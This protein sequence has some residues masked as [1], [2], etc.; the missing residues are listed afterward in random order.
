MI[1]ENQRKEENNVEEFISEDEKR[2]KRRTRR[3]HSQIVAYSVLLVMLLCIAVAGTIGIKKVV[4][5]ISKANATQKLASETENESQTATNDI[6]ILTPEED[7]PL[8]SSLSDED[9]ETIEKTIE[10]MSL[11]DKVASLFITTPEQITGVQSAIK[12]GT[13][14]QEALSNYAIGGLVYSSN[15]IKDEEQI[16]EMLSQTSNLSRYPIFLAVSEEG[17]EASIV[18]SALSLGG[19]SAFQDIADADDAYENASQMASYLDKYGFNLNLA[20]CVDMT[21]DSGSF[22]TDTEDVKEKAASYVKG[23][24]EAGVSS[25]TLSFPVSSKYISDCTYTADEIAENIYPIYEELIDADVDLIMVSNVTCKSLT[26]D[27]S[28]SCSMSSDIYSILRDELSFDKVIISDKLNDEKITSKYS[29]GDA[30]INA[31]NA[32]CD[33]LYLPEN[34]EEAYEAIL[35]AL[36]NGTIEESRIDESLYR[37]YNVKYARK[38]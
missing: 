21:S 30:A 17:G 7:T 12:A 14:T 32:G 18:A 38:S 1:E 36:Q 15:N 11:E 20:P 23:L 31:L 5:V 37:I 19:T 25:C 13:G 16:S 29:S 24:E 8:T 27:E 10:N 2:Q 3:V 6:T 22:G 35:E 34:F 9:V 26:N 4:N 33:M 28:L